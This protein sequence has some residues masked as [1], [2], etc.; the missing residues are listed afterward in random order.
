MVT[1]HSRRQERIRWEGEPTQRRDLVPREDV[2]KKPDLN[3]NI[4]SSIDIEREL[5]TFLDIMDS[6]RE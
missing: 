1:S 5:K 4:Q 2:T 6:E 3:K